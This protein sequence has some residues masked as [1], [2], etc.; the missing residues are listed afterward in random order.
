MGV[1]GVEGTVAKLDLTVRQAQAL[2]L[3][4][5]LALDLVLVLTGG[6][7]STR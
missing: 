5:M 1:V 6:Q 2:V 3:M 7:C 4:L